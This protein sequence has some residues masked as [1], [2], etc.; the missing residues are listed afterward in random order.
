MIMIDCQKDYCLY[1][2]SKAKE[3]RAEFWQ[4]KRF[5]AE[6]F[7]TLLVDWVCDVIFLPIKQPLFF[8]FGIFRLSGLL[9]I[10][11]LE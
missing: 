6:T 1:F 2:S 3:K 5:I 4:L 7:F 10:S 11:P 9:F 8:I